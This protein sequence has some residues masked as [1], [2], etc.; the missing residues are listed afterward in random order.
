MDY[1]MNHHSSA[2]RSIFYAHFINLK[3]ESWDKGVCLY[4]H[5]EAGTKPGHEP[6]FVWHP[7]SWHC[8]APFTIANFVNSLAWNCMPSAYN[9]RSRAT[10]CCREFWL[11]FP[12]QVNSLFYKRN[13]YQV[14]TLLVDLHSVTYWSLTT[15]YGVRRIV[16]ILRI[17]KRWLSG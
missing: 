5:R 17:N 2:K 16:P 1:P 11:G 8:C 15:P 13:E 12:M 3:T 6:W 7:G 9:H 4:S 10:L 14:S